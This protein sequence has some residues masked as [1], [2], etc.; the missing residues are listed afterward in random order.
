MVLLIYLVDW[1]GVWGHVK[2]EHKY[3]II[4]DWKGW[5][6]NKNGGGNATCN[7]RAVKFE[8]VNW[9]SKIR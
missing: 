8:V 7:T 5:L 4:I 1:Q 2:L 6:R 9:K 3:T